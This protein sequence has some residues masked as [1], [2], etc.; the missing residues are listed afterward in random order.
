LLPSTARWTLFTYDDLFPPP[1]RNALSGW[2]YLNLGGGEASDVAQAWVVTSQRA[3]GRYS[4]DMDAVAL[5][6]GCSAGV[7]KS[8]IGTRPKGTVVIGPLP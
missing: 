6:N 8:E 3:E 5:G 4:V 1:S 7:G 2:L